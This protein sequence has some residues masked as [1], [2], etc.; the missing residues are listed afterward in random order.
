M[1]EVALRK[2]EEVGQQGVIQGKRVK[3]LNLRVFNT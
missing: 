2:G 3:R 1:R